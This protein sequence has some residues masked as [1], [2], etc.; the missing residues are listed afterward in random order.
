MFHT[1]KPESVLFITLDSCRYDTFIRSGI[2]HIRSVGSVYR[3]IAPGNFT[4]SSHAAMFVGFTPGDAASLESFV[5]PMIGKIF[6]MRGGGF[7]GLGKHKF[8]LE[9][10]NIVAGFKMRG[11]YCLGTGALFW[12][13][14]TRK[15]GQA[16]TRDFHDFFFPG[17]IWY[18]EKQLS[19][20]DEKLAKNNRPVFVF[21]NIGETHFPYYHLGAQWNKGYNPCR[22][23][24]GE[25]ND[26]QECQRRQK[27]CL[28]YID[29]RIAPLLQSFSHSNIIITADHGDC[30]GEDD[31]W[32]HG[33]HHEKVLEVP[34]L[35][36][37][38]SDY[39]S[40]QPFFRKLM[41]RTYSHIK[42][43][44]K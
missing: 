14:H 40:D 26:V 41:G 31:L 32:G 43:I 6:K 7:S 3:C 34:L 35:M 18:L 29:A 19:W 39:D 37:L 21:L 9:G 16:L 27:A 10:E 25:N 17:N 33:M 22:P 38:T 20:L 11:Y 15:T 36:R 4:Y 5:N 44:L 12:F 42:D 8:I 1:A 13:D 2:P 24:A 28:E 23:M 30:W